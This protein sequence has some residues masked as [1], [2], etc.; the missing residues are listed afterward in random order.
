MRLV[1]LEA[2]ESR[3]PGT[4]EAIESRDPGTIWYCREV[5]LPIVVL[6]PVRVCMKGI[7]GGASTPL[8][9]WPESRRE[10]RGVESRLSASIVLSVETED[11]AF[12]CLGRAVRL[13]SS[14]FMSGGMR[15]ILRNIHPNQSEADSDI[16]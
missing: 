4:L 15:L 10:S 2:M 11:L 7:D 14:G 3:N 5:L 9:G 12:L 13:S 1:S 16:K 6:D 8:W